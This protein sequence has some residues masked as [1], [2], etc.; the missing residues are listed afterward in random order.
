MW[1]FKKRADPA[2]KTEEESQEDALLTAS[3]SNEYITKDQAMN[4]PTFSSCVNKIAESISTIPIRLYRVKNEQLEEIK[5]DKRTK[6]LNDD[7]G[8][9]LD[10]VQFKRAMV[11]DYGLQ[12]IR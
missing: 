6:L 1:P 10:G 2:E 9:T 3:L 12:C 7:T 5:D 4:V 8:D 11:K